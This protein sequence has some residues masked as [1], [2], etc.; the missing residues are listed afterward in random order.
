MSPF[1]GEYDICPKVKSTN[2]FHMEF[3][4]SSFQF[5]SDNLHLLTHILFPK[6]VKVSGELCSGVQLFFA[7]LFA[8]RSTSCSPC[9]QTNKQTETEPSLHGD[10]EKRPMSRAGAAPLQS[11]EPPGTFREPHRSGP[12]SRGCGLNYVQSALPVHGF[13]TRGFKHPQIQ[14][15][16]SKIY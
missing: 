12:A 8:W 2:F 9:K 13:R 15:T 3:S 7:F 1:Y 11:L 14:P 6:N 4:R 5:C 16:E 10:L